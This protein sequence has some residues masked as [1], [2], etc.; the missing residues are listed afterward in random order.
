M[1]D[2]TS[3]IKQRPGRVPLDTNRTSNARDT[4]LS[5]LHNSTFVCKSCKQ[6]RT[7]KGRK[8]HVAGSP[9]CG[10]DCSQCVSAR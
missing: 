4:T 6:P 9:R 1:K 2:A 3:H 5:G 10:W 8:M 7:A